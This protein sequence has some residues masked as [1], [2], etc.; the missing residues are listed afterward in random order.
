MSPVSSRKIPL[1][2]ILAYDS[3]LK[4]DEFLIFQIK[5]RRKKEKKNL[6]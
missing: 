2:V 1:I 5:I 6:S 4:H 3:Q